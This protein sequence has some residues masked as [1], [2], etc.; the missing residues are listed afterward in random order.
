MART[1]YRLQVKVKAEVCV[2][3][4]SVHKGRID[5]IPVYKACI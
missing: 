5:L 4:D 1:V 3:H 2:V